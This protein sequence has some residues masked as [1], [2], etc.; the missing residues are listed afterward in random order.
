MSLLNML[1]SLLLITIL[2][3][4]LW[5]SNFTY[6]LA[7]PVGAEN[8]AEV[9]PHAVPLGHTLFNGKAVC[10][11][12]HGVNGE[13]SKV[14]NPNVAR[15]KPHPTDLRHPTDKSIRQLYLIIKYG[16]PGT[17]M[18]SVQDQ[19]GLR[20]EDVPHLISYLLSLQGKHLVV[21]DILE[22]MYRRDT[23][24]DRAIVAM[25]EAEAIGDSDLKGYC[26]DRYA[27]RY[28]DLLIGRPPDIKASRYLKIQ[29]E[30]KKRFGTDLD[31]RALCYRRD[32]NVLRQAGH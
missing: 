29:T 4:P 3:V 18:V 24:T 27:K 28:I 11:A 14:T 19:T 22:Q 15:L 23:E 31:Q 30:C 10:F 5:G 32:L 16:I 21:D 6:V 2:A 7:S 8:E 13:P 20:D 1:R 17:A 9:D 26:E 25:C 12:C